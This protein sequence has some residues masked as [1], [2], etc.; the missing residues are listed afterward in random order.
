MVYQP[1]EIP[2]L[3]PRE[4][5]TIDGKP[6]VL[7]VE[8]NLDN[9]TTVKAILADGFYVLEA[10]DGN[11][12]VEMAKKHRPDLILMDIQ[13]P[14]LDGIGA[15]K[16]IRSEAR[17]Q[18]IPIIALTASAMTTERETILAHGFDAYIAKP[19]DETNFFRTIKEILY[20][21]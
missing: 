10:T 4:L 19:I 1:I 7:V 17:L 14:G 13:L 6:L 8:D 15:F 5:P 3:L 18:H 11:T 2:E 21:K 16:L 9:L 20:G 12:G